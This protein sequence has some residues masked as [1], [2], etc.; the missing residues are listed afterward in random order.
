MKFSVIC[1]NALVLFLCLMS[2]G[3]WSVHYAV[4]DPPTSPKNPFPYKFRVNQMAGGMV[5]N[6]NNVVDVAKAKN[7]LME[8]RPDMFT[9]SWDRSIPV[10]IS[11]APN[12]SIKA[13]GYPLSGLLF[14][15]T[16]GQFPG[17]S[18]VEI[19]FAIKCELEGDSRTGY[20]VVKRNT[21]LALWPC[22]LGFGILSAMAGWTPFVNDQDAH[23]FEGNKEFADVVANVIR[24]FDRS[25]IMREYN[26]LYG[27][28][29]ELKLTDN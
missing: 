2:P 6:G 16:A 21:F 28:K 5:L 8:K 10:N 26:R 14:L 25:D 23:P 15:C 13:G 22:G 27:E 18:D 11:L 4:K 20:F 9:S 7:V 1:A 19:P 17:F 24:Q 12:G 29:L 3:C